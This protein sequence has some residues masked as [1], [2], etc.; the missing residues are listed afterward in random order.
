MRQTEGLE[1]AR[2]ALAVGQSA[3]AELTFRRRGLAISL[4]F[5]V[6]VALGLAFKIRQLM[7]EQTWNQFQRQVRRMVAARRLGRKVGKGFYDYD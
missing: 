2:E 7:G 1:S 6:A 3:L 5:I 4:L